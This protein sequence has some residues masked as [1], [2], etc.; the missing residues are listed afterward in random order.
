M[1]CFRLA[2][3][4]LCACSLA[5]YPAIA[6]LTP[7]PVTQSLL[8]AK[9]GLRPVVSGDRLTA[10]YGVPIETDADPAT[11]TDAFVASFLAQHADALG[12]TGVTLQLKDKIDIRNGK[13]TVYT[14]EQTIEGLPVHGS[15]VKIPVLLG[16]TEKIGYTGMRLV[17]L[18]AGALPQDVLSSNDALVVVQQSPD[19]GHLVNFTQ[20]EKVVFEAEDDVVHRVWRFSGSD[21][22]ESYL[23]FIDTASGEIVDQFDQIFHGTISGTVV[24]YPTP[25]FQSTDPTCPYCCPADCSNPMDSTCSDCCPVQ[26]VEPSDCCPAD[27]NTDTSDRMTTSPT[28][29]S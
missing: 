5:V 19:F 16:A 12:V 26:N 1:T 7:T 27:S 21:D 14:Y 9:P 13:F 22:D 6:Q 18:P 25:C 3:G 8:L 15:T 17:P 23:F 28:Y 20:P 11:S 24:G 2:A 4:C 29:F 10:L